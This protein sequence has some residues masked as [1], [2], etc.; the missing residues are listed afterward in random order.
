MKIDQH[1][2]CIKSLEIDPQLYGQVIFNKDA[3]PSH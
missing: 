2:N 3:K 1:I